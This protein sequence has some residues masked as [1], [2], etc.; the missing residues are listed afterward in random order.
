M[1]FP[2]TMWRCECIFLFNIVI[3]TLSLCLTSALLWVLLFGNYAVPV[4]ELEKRRSFEEDSE[5]GSFHISQYYL[6][7][8]IL[9][10]SF[11]VHL[12]KLEISVIRSKCFTSKELL[13]F[14]EIQRNIAISK[15]SIS[16]DSNQRQNCDDFLLFN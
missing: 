13:N 4:T 6:I 3:D 16:I 14:R 8:P 9:I 10:L 5:R 11:S 15:Y 1:I 12:D 7:F 2:L